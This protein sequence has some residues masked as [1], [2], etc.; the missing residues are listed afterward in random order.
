[1]KFFYLILA[2]AVLAAVLSV[3]VV[4]LVAT[5]NDT[6]SGSQTAAPES[7]GIALNLTA[8]GDLPGMNKLTLVRS[9]ANVTGGTWSMTVLPANADAS[10]SERGTLT[11][12]VSSGTITVNEN[13]TLASAS[14]VQISIQSGTGEFASVTAGTATINLTANAENPSQLNGTLVLNF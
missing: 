5:Y 10:S 4:N 6:L 11:G 14:A 13:G 12:T 8:A 2:P 7:E 3:N 1:M 9:E